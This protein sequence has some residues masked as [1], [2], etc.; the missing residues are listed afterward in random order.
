MRS[1][2]GLSKTTKLVLQKNKECFFCKTTRNLHHH[3][4]FHG[5]ANRKKS[6]EWG[7]QVWLCGAH[8]N[9]SMDGVHFNKKKDD[10]LKKYA[11]TEFE[12]LYGHE[13]FMSIFHKNYLE[14]DEDG[15]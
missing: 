1:A 11:Q 2:K 13:K 10:M 8:H 6:V 12:K 4:V 9:L 5:T 3:E 15:I 14:G 7:C